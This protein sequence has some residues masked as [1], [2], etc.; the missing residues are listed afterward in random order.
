MS[1]KPTW[2]DKVQTVC[3]FHRE[4]LRQ[5]NNNGT[6]WTLEATAKALGK[7]IGRVSEQLMLGEG[8]KTHRKQ[9]EKFKNETDAVDFMRKRKKE[10]RMM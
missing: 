6:K 1:D 4:A 5:A 9:L 3:D 2:I 7:S 10:L 8:L